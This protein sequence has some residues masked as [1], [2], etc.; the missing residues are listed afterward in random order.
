MLRMVGMVDHEAFVF[1]V[2]LESY[3]VEP[4]NPNKGHEEL[5]SDNKEG[6]TTNSGKNEG[7]KRNWRKGHGT[8]LAEEGARED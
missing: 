8:E 3:L 1:S 4:G 2:H 6:V 5:N 7:K